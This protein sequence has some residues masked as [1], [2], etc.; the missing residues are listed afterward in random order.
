MVVP[1]IGSQQLREGEDE[2]PVGQGQQETLVH[3][4]REQE[5]PFLRAGGAEVEGFTGKWTEVLEFAVGIGAW[6]HPMGWM[7]ATPLE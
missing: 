5:S 3:V 7:R 6:F 2:L 1:E 4:L